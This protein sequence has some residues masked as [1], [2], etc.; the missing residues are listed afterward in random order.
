MGVLQHVHAVM[1][2]QANIHLIIS[3]RVSV[4]YAKKHFVI[5]RGGPLCLSLGAHSAEL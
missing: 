4:I 2:L 3:S 5:I 1:Q